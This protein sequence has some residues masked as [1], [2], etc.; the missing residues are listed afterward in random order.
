MTVL[1]E[2]PLPEEETVVAETATS[3]VSPYEE[4][5]GHSNDVEGS[6]V[7]SSHEKTPND[8]SSLSLDPAAAEAIRTVTS[9]SILAVSLTLIWT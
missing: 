8:P 1:V 5:N 4:L 3:D 6:F 2:V 9:I 7:P